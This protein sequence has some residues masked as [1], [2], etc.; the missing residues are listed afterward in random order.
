MEIYQF[1]ITVGRQFIIKLPSKVI[2]A[3]YQYDFSLNLYSISFTFLPYQLSG[4]LN[5]LV[6]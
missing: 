1:D 3:K 6:G 4:L 2:I 5:P